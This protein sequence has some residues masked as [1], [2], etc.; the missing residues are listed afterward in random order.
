MALAA[1]IRNQST[2]RIFA[3]WRFDDI[4][5]RISLPWGVGFLSF[6]TTTH[7]KAM[8]LTPGLKGPGREYTCERSPLR[9]PRAAASANVTLSP[10]R[11]RRPRQCYTVS[12]EKASAM[13]MN[14]H[15]RG[16]PRRMRRRVW[17][18]KAFSAPSVGGRLLVQGV[19]VTGI[20]SREGEAAGCTPSCRRRRRRGRHSRHSLVA[21]H[22]Q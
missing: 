20:E 19:K 1:A 18:L 13:Y 21:D 2:K 16:V 6:F 3:G 7:R 5:Q 12:S 17:P 8:S 4:L 15:D 14:V 10:R 9:C 11:R 22:H